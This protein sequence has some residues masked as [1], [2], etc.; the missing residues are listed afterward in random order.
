MNV[1]ILGCGWLG[2]ALGKQLI[3]NGNIVRGSSTQRGRLKELE[4]EGLVAFPI[5]VGEK[6][7]SGNL[8][9]FKE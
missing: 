8:D 2:L 1:G 9:F 3:K 7:I 6:E 5:S 4:D